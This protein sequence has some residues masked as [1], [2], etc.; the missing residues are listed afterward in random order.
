VTVAD[1]NPEKFALYVVGAG[2]IKLTGMSTFNGV[3]YAP[4]APISIDN[5]GVFYGSF[6]GNSVEVQGSGGVA[7]DIALRGRSGSS[8]LGTPTPPRTSTP[9]PFAPT[10]TRTPTR[11]PTRRWWW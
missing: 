2:P 9:T 11:T 7:Y 8:A 3:V 5:A 6:V 4:Q 10:A 1:P